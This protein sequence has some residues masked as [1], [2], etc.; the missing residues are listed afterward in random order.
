[1]AATIAIDWALKDTAEV[2]EPTGNI[3][4]GRSSIGYPTEPT[5]TARCCRYAASG[6]EM[7]RAALR[8]FEVSHRVLCFPSEV[9]PRLTR[10][11]IGAVWLEVLGND[12]PQEPEYMA[13]WAREIQ[14]TNGPSEDYPG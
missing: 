3:D 13:Y 8:G 14:W 10:L 11:R 1:M 2:Y 4:N 12:P 7:E 5:R 6:R 9:F